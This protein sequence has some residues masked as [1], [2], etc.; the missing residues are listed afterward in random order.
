MDVLMVL[1]FGS[2]AVPAAWLISNLHRRPDRRTH[3]K[4]VALDIFVF[5]A[6]IP[7]MLIPVLP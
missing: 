4:Y 2:G 6:L 1:I 5:I 7:V 3:R